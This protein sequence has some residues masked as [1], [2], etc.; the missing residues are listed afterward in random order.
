[1]DDIRCTGQET[2]IAACNFSGWGQHNCQHS[3][4][5]GIACGK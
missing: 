2:H 4:D 3:K 1:M 5:V